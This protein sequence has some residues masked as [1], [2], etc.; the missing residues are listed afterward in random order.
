MNGNYLVIIS[1]FE[2]RKFRDFWNL[3]LQWLPAA[4]CWRNLY[5]LCLPQLPAWTVLISFPDKCLRHNHPLLELLP[6]TRL[7]SG[8]TLLLATLNSAS[9]KGRL[10]ND[11]LQFYSLQNKWF[12]IFSEASRLMAPKPIISEQSS[13]FLP[14]STYYLYCSF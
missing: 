2:I 4:I 1:Q 7:G 3:Y 6:I 10:R 5:N 13:Q 8:H 11:Y 9:P 14:K 12:Q